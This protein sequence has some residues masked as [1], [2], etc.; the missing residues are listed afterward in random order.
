MAILDPARA[1]R[2]SRLAAGVGLS[3]AAT[4]IAG[5]V[6]LDG[7]RGRMW[8]RPSR[9][10]PR[11]LHVRKTVTILAAADDL[12]DFWRNLEN[13]P[14]I[15]A[16][17]TEVSPIDGERFRWTAR[18]PNACLDWNAEIV[19]DIPPCRIAWRSVPGSTV[20]HAGVA[21]FQ[22]A[23]RRP[24]TIVTLDMSIRPTSRAAAGVVARLLGDP[25]EAAIARDLEAFKQRAERGEIAAAVHAPSGHPR[26]HPGATSARHGHRWKSLAHPA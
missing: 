21:T 7:R 12:H 2:D 6:W 24:G 1:V 23:R 25:P 5:L 4:L 3:L 11:S 8:R 19:E 16:H 22:P 10:R 14:R 18:L 13:L 17:V 20:E 15:F 9:L 26:L